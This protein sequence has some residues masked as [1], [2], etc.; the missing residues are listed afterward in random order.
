MII[1]T[2][3]YEKNDSTS[4]FPIWNWYDELRSNR[5]LSAGKS[6]CTTSMAMAYGTGL[7]STGYGKYRVGK[8]KSG[9]HSQL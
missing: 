3:S 6:V 9:I 5:L 7:Q 2:V 1:Q 8:P 4:S